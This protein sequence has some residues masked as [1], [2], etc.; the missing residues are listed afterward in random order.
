M[1]KFILLLSVVSLFCFSCKDTASPVDSREVKVDGGNAIHVAPAK[2]NPEQKAQIDNLRSH[3]N[4][5]IDNRSQG[6]AAYSMLVVGYWV[7]EAIFSGG[8]RP[9]PVEPGYWI[10]YEDDFT[11]TYGHKSEVQGGGRYHLTFNTEDEPKLIMVD[12]NPSKSPEEWAIKTKEDIIIFVGSS[13]FGNN[14]RQMK[15]NKEMQ[16]P[17]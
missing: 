4:A 16:Q 6:E 11:Y 3:A 12:D 14:P 2:V 17:T 13:Y 9:K 1:N 8:T 5:L 15:L 7:Y 10:K